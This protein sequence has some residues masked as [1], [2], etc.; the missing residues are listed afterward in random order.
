MP[1][2]QSEACALKTALKYQNQNQNTHLASWEQ[3]EAGI[4]HTAAEKMNQSLPRDERDGQ[5]PP[6]GMATVLLR[7][8]AKRPPHKIKA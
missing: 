7:G 5:M 4:M 8:D 3:G 2:D 1:H 6:G